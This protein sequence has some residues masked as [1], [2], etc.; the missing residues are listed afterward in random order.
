MCCLQLDAGVPAAAAHTTTQ[1]RSSCCSPTSLSLAASLPA[2]LHAARRL[3]NSVVHVWGSQDYDTG[4]DTSR[5]NALVALLVFGDGW[6]NC[7]HAFPSSARHGLEWWQ[8]DASF[9]AVKALAAV[10][11]AWDVREPTEAQKA[12]KRL[13]RPASG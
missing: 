12:A 2:R 4:G 10:G 6:H 7:H 11:L 5:N 9:L 1:W 3:I 8:L 13:Q